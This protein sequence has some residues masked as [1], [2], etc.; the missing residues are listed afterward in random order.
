MCLPLGIRSGENR[1]C[2]LR[3]MNVA[4]AVAAAKKPDEQRQ[5]ITRAVTHHL[6]AAS[7]FSAALHSR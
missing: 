5:R 1:C 3:A 6:H 4:R 7:R 2:I